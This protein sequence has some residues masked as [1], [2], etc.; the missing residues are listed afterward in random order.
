MPAASSHGIILMNFN[1]MAGLSSP[2]S[3][4]T[5]QLYP[6]L[7][8]CVQAQIQI[9]GPGKNNLSSTAYFSISL[10]GVLSGVTGLV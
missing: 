6:A 5:L 10:P 7:S 2:V 3:H 9:C 1:E 8:L 4:H